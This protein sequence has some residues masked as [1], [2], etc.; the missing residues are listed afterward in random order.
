MFHKKRFLVVAAAGLLLLAGCSKPATTSPS[1]DPTGA[2][3]EPGVSLSPSITPAPTETAS[4]PTST[5]AP[6]ITM[7]DGSIL[8]TPTPSPVPTAKPTREP[9]VLPTVPPT[10][11]PRPSDTVRKY[12]VNG[13]EMAHTAVIV[14]GTTYLPIGDTLKAVGVEEKIALTLPEDPNSSEVTLTMSFV[15]D[16]NTFAT[17]SY[18]IYTKDRDDNF[19]AKDISVHHNKKAITIKGLILEEG[20][21]FATVDLFQTVLDLII[22]TNPSGDIV[23]TTK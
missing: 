13:K 6:V 16:K 12:L 2:T 1:P 8:L 14:N 15:K 17:V 20:L 4:G 22:T 7:P 10:P 19:L 21:P 23:A 18:T 3:E 5:P 9:E 11:T